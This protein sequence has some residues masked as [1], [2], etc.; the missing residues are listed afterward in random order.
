MGAQTSNRVCWQ[1]VFS[2]EID[3]GS[4]FPVIEPS[5][6]DRLP[7][8]CHIRPTD[9]SPP[10]RRTLSR[11]TAPFIRNGLAIAPDTSAN[12]HLSTIQMRPHC[13]LGCALDPWNPRSR[14]AENLTALLSLWARGAGQCA[15]RY[16]IRV[17]AQQGRLHGSRCVLTRRKVSPLPMNVPIGIIRSTPGMRLYSMSSCH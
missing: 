4:P 8:A 5:N 16:R 7:A 17:I 15:Q 11:R 10:G 6:P 14:F 9:H 2:V 13:L 1:S 3:R 12:T